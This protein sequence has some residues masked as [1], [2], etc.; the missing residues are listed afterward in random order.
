MRWSINAGRIFGIQ[1]RIHLT[2][3]LLLLFVF[4]SVMSEHGVRA[5]VMSALFICALFACVVIHEVGHSLIARRFGKEAKSITLLPI[6]G[7]AAIDQMPTKPG[8]EIAVSLIGPLINLVIA[9]ILYVLVGAKTGVALPNLYPESGK[10]FLAGLIGVNIMLAVFNLIPAFPMDGGRVLRGLLA[11]KMDYVQAT[12][13]AVNIGQAIAAFF[14]FFGLF[15]NFLLALIGIFLYLGAGSEKQQ[16]ILQS[17]LA[18][19]PAGEAMTT[20]YMTLKPDNS[21]ADALEHFHHGCQQDFPVIDDSG[22]QGIL[23]RDRILATI[24][25]SGLNV[26]VAEVMDKTFATVSSKMGLDQVYRIFL[27]GNKTAVAVMDEGRLK[28][29]I[30]L[31]GISRYF[32]I[33]AALKGVDANG[34]MAQMKNAM[35]K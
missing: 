26:P 33:R 31:D 6:G 10:V 2:F 18:E 25:T 14:I 27:S 1:L 22:L 28:G 3:F 11:M 8:Q 29:I 15:Y 7:V 5:A 32:M 30:G 13:W 24:H 12:T 23:T 20:E 35:A 34:L 16:V 19:V 21:L 9:G 17:L 4:A